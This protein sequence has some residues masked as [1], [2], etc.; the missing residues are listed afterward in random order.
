MKIKWA[1]IEQRHANKQKFFNVASWNCLP[2]RNRVSIGLLKI[3]FAHLL[4]SHIISGFYGLL[5][6]IRSLVNSCREELDALRQASVAQRQFVI[7]L[8][9]KLHRGVSDCLT[10]SYDCTLNSDRLLKIRNTFRIPMSR[11]VRNVDTLELPGQ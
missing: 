11:E 1:T 6:E 3:F 8:G 7:S 2:Q 5:H 9:G 4:Y 10:G